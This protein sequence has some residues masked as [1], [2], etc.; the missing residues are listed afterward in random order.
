MKKYIEPALDVLVMSQDKSLLAA[1]SVEVGSDRLSIDENGADPN[2]G[3]S[4]S[5][6]WDE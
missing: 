1:L 6:V 2:A 3:L 5:S 4:K